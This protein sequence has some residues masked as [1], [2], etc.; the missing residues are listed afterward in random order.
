MPETPP[1]YIISSF[2]LVWYLVAFVSSCII[3]WYAVKKIIFITQNRKIYDLPDDTRK[4][5]GGN[6]PSL[7]GIG[8]FIGFIIVASFFLRAE[9]PGWNFIIVSSVI[10][11]FTGIYDDLMNMRPSRKLMAQIFASF[12]T[13]YYSGARI[14]SFEGILGINELPFWVSIGFSTIFCTFFINVFNFIDGIDGLACTFAIFYTVLL[15]LMLVC[16]GH[17]GAATISFSMAGATTGLLY[18]NKAPAK[19]YMG[20]TGS[21]VLGFV[22]FM[23]SILTLNYFKSGGWVCH[24][25]AIL[26]PIA[27]PQQMALVLVAILYLPIFDAIRIFILRASKGNSP[28]KADR[29][30]L[31]YYLLDAGF[32]HT[33]SVLV[34]L[35]TNLAIIGLCYALLPFHY[36][37]VIIGITLFSGSIVG[38][39]HYQRKNKV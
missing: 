29:N 36:L 9:P 3:S 32:S 17:T 14:T 1:Q 19:I 13:I 16:M 37:V 18:Y 25:C 8:V 7:G 15:G 28:L 35:A 5:H 12:I 22:I 31:H 20:D 21:M 24:S 30:H 4:F 11:F 34:L 26:R 6:I 33:F 39:I 27:T 2:P 23:F 10:L 38:F